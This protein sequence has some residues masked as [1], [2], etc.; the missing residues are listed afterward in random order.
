MRQRWSVTG[1]LVAVAGVV[2]FAWFVRRAGPSEIWQG[3]RS[4][5][6]G[7]VPIIA[8]TGVRFALRAWALTLCVEPQ[9]RVPYRT[10]LA[11]VIA[12]DA[13]GNLTPLGLIVSEPTKAAFIRAGGPL[14]PAITAVAVETLIY[15]LSV[16][17]MIAATTT[18]LLLSFNLSDDMR[19]AAWFAVA[20]IAVGFVAT[21]M[22]LWRQ[23]VIMRRVLSSILPAG[24]RAESIVG[25]LHDMEQQ[26]LTFAARR[27]DVLLPVAAAEIAFHVL[28]V[29][30]IALTVW[31]IVGTAPPLLTAFILEG[32]NRLVQVVFKPVP[33]RAG[34][35]EIT[36]G[37][38]TR[39]LGY[40]LTLGTTMAIVRKVRTIFWALV[41]TFLLVRK[42]RDIKM[43]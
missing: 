12:G 28:G 14:R 24:A 35:D 15:T 17:A 23:P 2:L 1:V 26:I 20:A 6:W 4:I 16:A 29:V 31:L 43:R 9:D 30:E 13:A 11:G 40:N 19:H 37:T 32:A 36:T 8:L 38:F 39:L 27:R 3:L 5:G 7:F 18:A 34:V 42:G 41:G 22:L 21:A 25:K 10:A 33:L